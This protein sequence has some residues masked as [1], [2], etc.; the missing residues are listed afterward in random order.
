MTASR[1][2]LVEGLR[3]AGVSDDRLL[4]ASLNFASLTDEID[5]ATR[6]DTQAATHLLMQFVYLFD[7]QN[8]KPLPPEV[9]RYLR[10]SFLRMARGED[11]GAALNLKRAGA[12][13]KY[14]HRLK[15]QIGIRIEELRAHGSALE[16]ACAIVEDEIRAKPDRYGVADVP[17]VKALARMV[18]DVKD[19]IAALHVAIAEVHPKTHGGI[20]G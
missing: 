2:A 13:T 3:K 8:P 10:W 1:Q 5:R 7:P 4:S 12:P 19:E 16:Q 15:M 11:A 18:A 14:P 6:G 9:L 20:L 17:D